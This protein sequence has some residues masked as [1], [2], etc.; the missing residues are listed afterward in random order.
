MINNSISF[1]RKIPVATCQVK[2]LEKNKYIPAVVY[3]FDCHDR[4]DMEELRETDGE[5][6]FKRAL[7]NDMLNT[8]GR[9]LRG[10]TDDS[11]YFVLEDKKSKDIIGM[12]E[13]TTKGKTINIEY[14]ETEREKKYKYVGQALI[15]AIGT[16]VLHEGGKKLTVGCPYRTALSFYEDT[17][18]FDKSQKGKLQFEEEGLKKFIKRTGKR[19][20]EKVLNVRA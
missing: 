7:Y 6:E 17:C 20:E 18:Q 11:R 9:I 19:T 16:E 14:L 4:S 5:W 10:G 12:S 2:N 1:G 8:R 3:E 13:V 15:A